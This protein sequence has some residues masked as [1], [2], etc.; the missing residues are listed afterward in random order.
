MKNYLENYKKGV[1]RQA[2]KLN[3]NSN[4]GYISVEGRDG[5][6]IFI[7]YLP[8]EKIRKKEKP[9]IQIPLLRKQK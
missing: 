5:K 6:S 2:I 3:I 7:T 1:G 8:I 9:E 4:Q